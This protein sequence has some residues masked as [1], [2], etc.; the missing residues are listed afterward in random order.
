MPPTCS[1]RGKRQNFATCVD[2]P[3]GAREIFES[4]V[5]RGRVLTCVRPLLRRVPCRGPRWESEDQGQFK[6]TRWK[7]LSQ[8][9]F[10]RSGLLT[11]RHPSPLTFPRLDSLAV[12]ATP[13]PPQP[14]LD[15]PH[16]A[17]A[18]PRRSG[19]RFG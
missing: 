2:A 14:E 17:P 15:K 10:S 18:A 5:A 8:S 7:R 19:P 1:T 13:T 16:R 4:G 6:P 12:V 9:W 11:V 3:S